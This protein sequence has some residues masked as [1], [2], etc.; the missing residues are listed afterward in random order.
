MSVWAGVNWDA[1]DR[2]EKR[3]RLSMAVSRQP[4][5]MG[6]LSEA[7]TVTARFDKVTVQSASQIGPMPISVCLNVF[8]IWLVVGNSWT[9]WGMA[10]SDVPA[11]LATWSFAVTTFTFGAVVLVFVMGAS[12][13]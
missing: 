9:S 6:V 4:V 8:M 7:K 10:D 5:R 1:S 11:E 13:V 2:R 3:H 12:R